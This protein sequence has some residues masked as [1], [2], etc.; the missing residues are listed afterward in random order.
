MAAV[1]NSC[2]PIGPHP[3][4]PLA[5]AG[6]GSAP[7]TDEEGRFSIADIPIGIYE[8]AIYIPEDNKWYT[9]TSYG[10][11]VEI[12]IISGENTDIGEINFKE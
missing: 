11:S 6:N 5:I 7:A 10:V 9:K 8:Y 3:Y 12:H 4:S 1:E 2:L